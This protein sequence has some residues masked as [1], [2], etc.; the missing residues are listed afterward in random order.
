M[1]EK[2]GGKVT[3]VARK[4]GAWL[5]GMAF[6]SGWT[7]WVFLGVAAA[8]FIAIAAIICGGTDYR[9]DPSALV[10]RSAALYA[11]TRDLGTLL[12]NT[13]GWNVWREIK[14]DGVDR[15]NQMPVAFAE[16]IG[17]KVGGLGTRLPLAWLAGA[18]KAAI[19]F[20]E[21]ESGKPESWAI[22]LEIPEADKSLA[23]LRIEPG[24]TLTKASGAGA[25]GVYVL[26][27]SGDGKLYLGVMSPWLIVSSDDLLPNFAIDSLRLPSSTLA[28][29]DVLPGWRRDTAVRGM[30]NPRYLSSRPGP[31]TP[32][33]VL[34]NWMVDEARWSFAAGVTKDGTMDVKYAGSVMMGQAGGGGVLW[35]VVKFILFLIAVL[36]LVLVLGTLSIMIGLGGWYKF[37]AVKA[38][39]APRPAPA[40]VEPSAAFQEDSG[41]KAEQK[42]SAEADANLPVVVDET[43]IKS[44]TGIEKDGADG[45]PKDA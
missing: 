32:L 25:G 16:M 43:S 4:A 15:A 28:N 27:G 10:P 26:S 31:A 39:L 35:P 9:R 23:D 17:A 14:R 24:L 6:K 2:T 20:A 45:K 12:K 8:L 1:A 36:C 30:F 21:G 13:A 22:Y 38:G 11:E 7:R 29:S 44:E 34:G 41:A 19:G 18:Q 3:A 33:G 37:L 5:Y 40:S 42:P